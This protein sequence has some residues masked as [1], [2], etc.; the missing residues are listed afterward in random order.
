MRKEPIENKRK[1]KQAYLKMLGSGK[2][3]NVREICRIADINKSTFYRHYSYL[4]EL[5]KEM[6]VEEAK[7]FYAYLIKDTDFNNI[8]DGFMERVFEYRKTL[9]KERTLFLDK[10]KP[11]AVDEVVNLA[12][13]GVK[14]I[15]DNINNEML[16]AIVVRG[17]MY[18]MFDNRY[19]DQEKIDITTKI[20][21][22]YHK[23]VKNNYFI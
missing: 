12:I 20:T 23:A 16:V 5:E 7:E 8:P 18:L 19:T 13:E 1:I 6:Y 9:S 17:S 10:N 11:V 2:T 3:P 22:S 14:K 4:E 15:S 21:R